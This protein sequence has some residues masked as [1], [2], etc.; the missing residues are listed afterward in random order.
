MAKIIQSIGMS[1]SPMMAADGEFWLEFAK[2]DHNHKGLFDESGKHVTY[3]ELN[4][5]RQGRYGEIAMQSNMVSL[6]QD[7]KNSFARLKSDV[8]KMKPDIIIVVSND[9]D[10]EWFDKWNI[11]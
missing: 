3:D 11:P 10:G 1:H 9:H 7:M 6:H 5:Q 4:T 2:A 8:A